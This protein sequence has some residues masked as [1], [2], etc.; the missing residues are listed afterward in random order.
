MPQIL[1][2]Y[3]QRSGIPSSVAIVIGSEGGFSL[4]ETR[5]AR[6]AGFVL[7]GLGKRILRTETAS[8]CVLSCLMYQY[9]L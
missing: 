4:E 5:K 1:A 7:A 6:E 2:E 9:E 3:E 8:G